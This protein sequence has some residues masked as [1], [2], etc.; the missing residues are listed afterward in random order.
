MKESP[1]DNRQEGGNPMS[2]RHFVLTL[3]LTLTLTV[4]AAIIL[5]M[6]ACTKEAAETIELKHFPIDNIAEIITGSGVRLDKEVSSDGNGSLRVDAAP[7]RTVVR[8]FEIKDINIENARLVY[9]AR[10]RTENV[11][12]GVYLEMWCGFTGK[13]EFFSRS[14][15]API[16][17]TNDWTT[18]VT[19]FFLNKGEAPDYV[20]LNLVVEGKGTAWIDDVGLFKAPLQ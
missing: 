3:T 17:G 6:A 20:K 4:A 9:Q 14:L 18:V 15:Y 10:V 12:G 16:S 5:I 11:E 19:P 13:G 8:L 2:T 1:I 7:G